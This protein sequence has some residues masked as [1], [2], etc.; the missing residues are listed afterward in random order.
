[1]FLPPSGPAT[2]FAFMVLMGLL[3]NR[4]GTFSRGQRMGNGSE[5]LRDVFL[6]LRQRIAQEVCDLLALLM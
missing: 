5:A 1:M 2:D 6:S 3:K 4:V